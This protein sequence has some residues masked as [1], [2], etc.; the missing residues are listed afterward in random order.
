[1]DN[2]NLLL[3]RFELPGFNAEVA[4]GFD[5]CRLG[6]RIKQCLVDISLETFLFHGGRYG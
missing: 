3:S 2:S 5:R 6:N 4:Y 1:M